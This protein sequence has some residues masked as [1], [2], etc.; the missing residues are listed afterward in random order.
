MVFD[1]EDRGLALSVFS[2]FPTVKKQGKKYVNFPMSFDI[3]TTSFYAIDG[4]AI[5]S[6]SHGTDSLLYR[7]AI[8]CATMYVWQ[9]AIC[10]VVIIGRTWRQFLTFL[11]ELR[12]FF[13]CYDEQY[14]IIYV[15]NLAYEFQFLRKRLKWLKVFSLDKRI[16][17]SAETDKNIIFKCSYKLS[18]YSLDTVAKNLQKVKIKKLKGALRYDELRHSETVLTREELEYCANDVLIV[19]AYIEEQIEQWHDNIAQ[20]PLTQTGAVRRL[21]RQNCFKYRRYKWFVKSLT[22]QV[23]EY[24]TVKKAYAGGFVHCNA[25][26]TRQVLSN[27]SS[28]DFSSS[29]PSVMLSEK[30]PMTKGRYVHIE[31]EEEILQ[32]AKNYALVLDVKFLNIKSSRLFERVLS[33]SKCNEISSDYIVDNGRLDSASYVRTCVTEIDFI[34]L[35]AFYSWEQMRVISCVMYEKRY[36]PLPI[37]ATVIDLYEKKTTLKNVAGKEKEYLHSKELLNSVYGMCVTNIVRNEYLYTDDDWQINEADT[38]EE[39]NKYNNDKS[40]FLFYL[41]GVYITAYARRNLYSAIL[42]C[43]ND[44]VYS[45]T[46]SVKILNAARH[47]KYFDDYNKAVQEKT[48]QCLTWF[49]IPISAAAPKNKNG[50]V[51]PIGIWEYEG[52]YS[53]FKS[54]GAKRYLTEQDGKISATVAGLSKQLGR[55]YIASQKDPFLYFNDMMTID[56]EH[57]GRLI[58]TYC[59][60]GIEGSMIDLN[61]KRGNYAEL[62]YVHLEQGEYNLSM[63]ANYLDYIFFRAR[64]VK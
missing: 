2:N 37:I 53:K 20:I 39:I 42:E 11:D 31:T 62:S 51:K 28:Y 40:R 30:Y 14:L 43:K 47:K 18:G 5:D 7:G 34:N 27:V 38:T 26:Y 10:D 29:Y 16:P 36:L 3:E 25:C 64:T 63:V 61:G 32:L 44:Y 35:K 22:F 33:I 60:N 48:A 9:F 49:N 46:D 45:D 50:D 24:E 19:T 55:D 15:H 54:L 13:N 21:T 6:A 41:W 57:S 58:H 1:Y 12:D 17:I 59:D 8:K 52:T 23:T 56:K 4:K